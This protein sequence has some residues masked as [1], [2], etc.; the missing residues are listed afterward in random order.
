VTNLLLEPL[1]VALPV[2]DVLRTI[3]ERSGAPLHVVHRINDF[4]VTEAL[5]AAG[6]G[7]A[8]L[9]RY[10]ADHRGGT[11]FTL[12]PLEGIRA[13][14]EID[15]LSRPDRAER[16]VVKRVLRHLRAAARAVVSAG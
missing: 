3:G 2:F 12:R 15:A 4:H 14:R 10:T 5:V 8:L 9:P 7:T 1:D 6:H 13:S 11:R 16:V